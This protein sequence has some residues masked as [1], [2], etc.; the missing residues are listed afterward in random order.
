MRRRRIC[1][2]GWADHVHLERWASYF[3]R[4]GDEVS[5]LSLSGLG[6]YPEGVR[7]QRV[8]LKG[9]GAR[10]LRMRLR[11]LLWR[12][13]PDVV[14]VYWAHFAALVRASWSGPLAVTAW[15]SDIY[16]RDEF[17]DA[18]WY[19]LGVALRGAQLLSCDSSDL[20]ATMTRSFS[21]PES[22][23]QVIQ[24]GVDTE[25]FSANG[26]DLRQQL[27]LG[28]RP[29]VLSARNFT[30]LYNQETVVDAFVGV[31]RER[32][33]AF[34]LM[35]SYNGDRSYIAHIHERI[36]AAGLSEHVRVLDTVAY[37]E[38][39]QLYRTADAMVSVPTSDAAPM[40]LFEAMS[41]GVPS[42]V[43]DLP[44]LREWVDDGRTGFLVEPRDTAAVS[45]A[46][47]RAL[48]NGP[49]RDD[50]RAAARALVIERASQHAHMR[51]AGACYDALIRGERPPAVPQT[52]RHVGS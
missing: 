16:R 26:P 4:H 1:F 13:Q 48:A 9:R 31:R 43:C 39:P 45:A 5:V 24:W 42:V 44:S 37:D 3:A 28:S 22:S 30:P 7:Q 49:E 19:D 33:D 47:L 25:L 51:R 35:K 38:M 11:Y 10:W 17:G 2:V 12:L 46:L 41:T 18:D 8:G 32:R 20:A 14:H 36:A 52:M 40:S 27:G 21:L 50:M 23:V 34:L 6:R 15:G 29:V